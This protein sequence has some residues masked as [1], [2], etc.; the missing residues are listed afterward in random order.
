[1]T[2]YL[3]RHPLIEHLCSSYDL[4][5]LLHSWAVLARSTET[6]RK[7]IIELAHKPKKV[8]TDL[9]R[10]QNVSSVFARVERRT[11]FLS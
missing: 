8:D 7:P 5:A 6:K 9:F 10:I 2:W 3:P 11:P 1:M 4:R